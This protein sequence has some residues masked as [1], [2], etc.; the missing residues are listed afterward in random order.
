[1]SRDVTAEA[2]VPRV[3]VHVITLFPQLF[4]C[5]LD[6]GVVSRAVARRLVD[7][8]LVNL[9]NFG[10]GRHHITDDYPFG[11]GA[12]MV[13]KVE[14]LFDAV[15]SLS[16]SADVPVILLGP[17][18]RRFDQ[19]VAEE[20]SGLPRCALVCGHYEGVDERVRQHLVTDEISIGDYIVSSG[21][22]A[23][24]VVV[25]AMVRLVPGVIAE[26]STLEESFS[27]GLLEYPQYTRPAEYRGW[28]VPE[29]LLSGH[30]AEIARWRREQALQ[31]TRD[32]RPDL[33]KE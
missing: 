6:Q 9:R 29:V 8:D 14:P 21:E 11:G 27:E 2:P 13:M 19:R 10:V 22:I 31:R 26:T 15:E 24:M 7:I 30:H 4:S 28:S 25:D 16:L 1:V 18:G 12:G 17:T 20:L 23:A 33:L 5:W 32:R 3:R